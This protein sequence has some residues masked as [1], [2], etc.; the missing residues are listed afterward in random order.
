[1]GKLHVQLSKLNSITSEKSG[2]NGESSEAVTV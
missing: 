1:M 2:R